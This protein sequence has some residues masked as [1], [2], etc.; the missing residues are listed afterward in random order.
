MNSAA[1]LNQ[2]NKAGIHFMTLVVAMRPA[3]SDRT[4]NQHSIL[5]SQYRKLK[6]LKF[7]Q[8]NFIAYTQ[9]GSP[10]FATH[11]FQRID[12]TATMHTD[13]SKKITGDPTVSSHKKS[14]ELS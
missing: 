9:V 13:Q 2:K 7:Q 11:S 3:C 6:R 5:S 8:V 12:H 4:A 10:H 1:L 14:V